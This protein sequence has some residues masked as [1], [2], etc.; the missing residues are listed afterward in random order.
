MRSRQRRT[1]T[2]RESLRVAAPPLPLHCAWSDLARGAAAGTM[3]GI[4]GAWAAVPLPVPF[5][6]AQA[7]A[8]FRGRYGWSF[9]MNPAFRARW[10]SLRTDPWMKP[11]DI[12]SNGRN[13]NAKARFH[14]APLLTWRRRRPAVR[15]DGAAAEFYLLLCACISH[16]RLGLFDYRPIMCF[17]RPC[18]CWRPF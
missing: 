1:G 2:S 4:K 15:G 12:V 3:D 6:G 10:Y 13:A 18:C 9:M 5:G 7:A 17:N 8:A 14:I 16:S 11:A